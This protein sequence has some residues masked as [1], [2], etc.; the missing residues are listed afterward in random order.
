[1]RK[2]P[3]LLLILMILALYI[4]GFLWQF[5]AS[6]VD[7]LKY[8]EFISFKKYSIHAA[9]S[10][11][12]MIL[13]AL[14][15]V[16]II[17]RFAKPLFFISLLLL[18][19]VYIPGFSLRSDYRRW[20][21]IGSFSFQPSELFKLSLIIYSSYILSSEYLLWKKWRYI[22]PL[23]VYSGIGIL[24]IV[25]EKDLST[26]A[27]VYFLLMFMLY[28]GTWNKKHFLVPLSVSLLFPV[29][30][31][32]NKIWWERIIYTLQPFKHNTDKSYQIAQSLIAIGSGGLLGRGYMMG[33][34]KFDYIPY[35]FKDFIFSL[36]CEESGF[37]GGLI[38]I[39]LLLGILIK[40]YRVSVKAKDPF[41]KFISFGIT[42]HI[43]LQSFIVI[44]V[45]IGLL[46]VTGLPFPFLSYGGTAL[47]INGIEVGL[48]INASR[49]SA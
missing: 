22:F 15:P 38:I 40:G 17:K 30:I 39:I 3:D 41:L 14:V 45:N 2:N 31:K 42:T 47:L 34:Q 44:G 21:I 12:A 46:P 7:F 28:I 4:F 16:K 32:L 1:M 48:L 27:L 11:F 8:G 24:L 29:F 9:I 49:S 33:K 18:I 23:I 13:F 36:I 5:S 6:S 37:I 10:I 35:V 20:I 43:V 19:L 26:G 25:F